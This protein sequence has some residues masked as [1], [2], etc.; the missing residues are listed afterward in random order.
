[1]YYSQPSLDVAATALSSHS[2][3][4]HDLSP[5]PGVLILEEIL[6]QDYCHPP[7]ILN[8]CKQSRINNSCTEKYCASHVTIRNSVGLL[9]TNS[10]HKY[11]EDWS[12]I[13]SQVESEFPFL[14]I[15]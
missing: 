4:L 8:W 1:M 11:L 14:K 9:D 2:P 6:K 5:F 10:M 7:K 12:F 3:C 13:K 15:H